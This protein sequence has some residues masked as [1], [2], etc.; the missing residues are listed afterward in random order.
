M[1]LENQKLFKQLVELESIVGDA[2]VTYAETLAKIKDQQL[3]LQRDCTWEEY[4]RQQWGISE[5]TYRSL[6]ASAKMARKMQIEYG[7]QLGNKSAAR[8]LRRIFHRD[9]ELAAIVIQKAQQH[10]GK[11]VAITGAHI[12]AVEETLKT[13]LLTDGHCDDG[14]GGMIAF[15]AQV[16]MEYAE[17]VARRKQHAVDGAK[18][19]GWS[20]ATV[21]TI[22]GRGVISIDVGEIDPLQDVEVKWRVIE[23]ERPVNALIG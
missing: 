5:S 8:E 19:N 6:Q 4:L 12:K 11:D 9:S 20:N 7:A 15:D 13:V 22:D 1:C 16:D 2:I 10:A 17:L 18:A 14:D 3:Y 21:L 23:P